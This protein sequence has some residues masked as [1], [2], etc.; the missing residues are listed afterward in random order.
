MPQVCGPLHGLQAFPRARTDHGRIR[1]AH[2]LEAMVLHDIARFGGADR[3]V[4][5]LVELGELI[6]G[7]L[8]QARIAQAVG[9]AAADAGRLEEA[10]DR[11]EQLGSP[12]FAAES[13]A[14]LAL[15]HHAAGRT[16]EALGAAERARSIRATADSP[17]TTPALDALDTFLRRTGSAVGD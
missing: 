16:T 14:Q 15:L 2:A 3:V 7:P 1:G 5:R 10:V 6:D 11:Y 13:G 4:D 8:I 12:L 17:I 9:V